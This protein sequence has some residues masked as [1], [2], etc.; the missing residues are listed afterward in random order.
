MKREFQYLQT[1]QRRRR[2]GKGKLASILSKSSCGNFL[3]IFSS[4]LE[5]EFS[6]SSEPSK[7]W[8][9]CGRQ[10]INESGSIKS[11]SLYT[12][13]KVP[14]PGWLLHQIQT[15]Q[16]SVSQRT[17]RFYSKQSQRLAMAWFCY[18]TTTGCDIVLYFRLG[19]LM[20]TMTPSL[21]L[22]HRVLVAIKHRVVASMAKTDSETYHAVLK[23]IN[24]TRKRSKKRKPK[25]TTVS[26]T[27]DRRENGKRTDVKGKI[28][29]DERGTEF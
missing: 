14:L 27:E 16:V 29:G 11:A 26:Q 18:Y 2:L 28:Q 21:I 8:E 25:D 1:V 4:M 10:A 24:S 20:S 5:Q 22:S 23:K 6:S 15:T 7:W 17:S 9:E 3:Q 19:E 13:R 12:P